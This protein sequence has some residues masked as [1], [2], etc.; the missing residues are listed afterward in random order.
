MSHLRVALAPRSDEDI[1]RMRQGRF[2]EVRI[3]RWM[4]SISSKRVLEDCDVG[5]EEDEDEDDPSESMLSAHPN[6]STFVMCFDYDKFM[7]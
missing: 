1:S 3:S 6:N 2:N 4:E 7:F 5:G